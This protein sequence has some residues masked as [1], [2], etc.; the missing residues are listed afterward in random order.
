ME[1][2]VGMIHD[3]DKSGLAGEYESNEHGQADDKAAN[4]RVVTGSH[5]LS[6]MEPFY[7]FVRRLERQLTSKNRAGRK[8]GAEIFRA[9]VR[10]GPPAR[11]V[12]FQPLP[13]PVILAVHAPENGITISV[14][15]DD[16]RIH[17]PLKANA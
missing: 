6:F 12:P 1:K 8:R 4:P 17:S 11:R 7:P 10:G 2:Q 13:W 15:V 5:L 9:V 14:P 16:S 3:E